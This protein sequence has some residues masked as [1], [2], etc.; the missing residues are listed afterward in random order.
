LLLVTTRF[1]VQ[2]EGSSCARLLPRLNSFASYGTALDPQY[3]YYYASPVYALTDDGTPKSGELV[4]ADVTSGALARLNTPGVTLKPSVA[5]LGHDSDS[6]Y[7]ENGD[8]L[9]A[10]RKP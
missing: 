9:L 5:V 3:V 4:R 6:L 2:E 8:T 1:F 10:I 7:I